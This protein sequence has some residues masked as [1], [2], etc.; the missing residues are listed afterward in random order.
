MRVRFRISLYREGKRLKKSDFMN[1][2]DPLY[3]GM[4]YIIEFKYLEATKWLLIASDCYEKYLLLGL[5]NLALGQ[6][7]QAREFFQ[8]LDGTFPCTDIRVF[9]ENP[10]NGTKKEVK[11]LSDLVELSLV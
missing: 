8:S 3:K 2:R 4:R 9:V 1:K 5:V 11:G 10:E 6:E 7:E